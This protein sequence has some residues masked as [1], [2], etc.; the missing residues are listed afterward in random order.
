MVI[1]ADRVTTY[2]LTAG[3]MLDVEDMIHL[4]SPHDTP[5]T[6]GYG[7]DGLTVFPS[8]PVSQVKT[9]WLH[10][11]ILTPRSTAAATQTTG[12][13]VV[14][15]ASGERIRFS[16]GDIVLMGSG[17][18]VRVTGYG[19]TTDVLLI[20]RGYA[21]STAATIATSATM[22]IIGQAL[23][24]GADPEN[25]R[26]K[27]RTQ[28]FNYTQIFGPTAVKVSGTEM[29]INKYGLGGTNEFQHQL[30]RRIMEHWIQY[31]QALMY[32]IRLNDT[33]N[34]W[35][36]MGGLS[37]YITAANGSTIDS[38]TTTFSESS[39]LTMAQALYD[40]GGAPDRAIMGS[41]NKRLASGF[42]SSGT[43]Q[44]QRPDNGRGTVV[45]Y[46]DSDFGRLSFI[47]DRWCLTKDV[48]VL[49]REQVQLAT[50]RPLLFEV[51]AKTGDS[52][53]GMIVCEKTLKVRR[54]NHAGRYTALT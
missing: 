33:T 1:A 21:S 35:R 8:G 10:E 24:E 4:L 36:T 29:V 44:L 20:S 54:F 34:G 11:E 27:D 15:V 2:D 31:E 9:E 45:T 28:P 37:F 30:S 51:L 14:T 38:S 17:E 18:Y 7:A 41:K 6:G 12:D 53:K 3:T 48:F 49:E 47:L 50:L 26:V 16:T 25:P 43:L 23:A 40:A 42:T 46:F 5:L 13:T 52:H 19:V 39:L 22:L 32:G